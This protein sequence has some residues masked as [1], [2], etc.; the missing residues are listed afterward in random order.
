MPIL[1]RLSIYILYDLITLYNSARVNTFILRY[2]VLYYCQL[3]S[4]VQLFLLI[5]IPLVSWKISGGDRADVY[6]DL[7][8]SKFVFCYNIVPRMS[9]PV[10]YVHLL[11]VPNQHMCNIA[12]LSIVA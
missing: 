6:N 12:A 7:L 2:T 11:L 9:T 8:N 5:S 4:H 3:L 10:V 1:R